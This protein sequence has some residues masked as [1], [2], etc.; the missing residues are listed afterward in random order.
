MENQKK[1]GDFKKKIYD[2]TKNVVFEG[3]KM[4]PFGCHLGSTWALMGQA[5]PCHQKKFMLPF[6]DVIDLVY[7]DICCDA[8][9][10]FRR[11]R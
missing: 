6:A 10:F 1:R 5:M 3:H 7:V 8:H 9:I 4:L 2:V 11:Q